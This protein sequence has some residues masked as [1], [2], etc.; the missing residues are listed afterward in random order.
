VFAALVIATMPPPPPV[1]QIVATTVIAVLAGCGATTLFIY[2]RNLSSDPY[3]IAAVDAT[4]AGE[5]VFTLIG[6]MLILGAT[7]PD[8]VGWAGFAAVVTGLLGL[9]LRPRA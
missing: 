3:R 1:Q 4:Q 8:M 2:A 7:W 9:S 6:E 5:A